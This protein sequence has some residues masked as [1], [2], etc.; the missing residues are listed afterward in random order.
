[1]VDPGPGQALQ[2]G[3]P[4]REPVRSKEAAVNIGEIARRA[5]VSRSTV[6]YVLS[7]K[8]QV[9]PEL[10]ERVTRVVEESG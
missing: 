5:G 1:M 9:S 4:V 6:S 8:R 10:H 7:G 2:S 3:E